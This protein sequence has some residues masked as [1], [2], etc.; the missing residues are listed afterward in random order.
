V[1]LSAEN[2]KTIDGTTWFCSW[3][4]VLSEAAAIFYKVDQLY[5]KQ[6]EEVFV[7]MILAIDWQLDP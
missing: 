5:N 1:V 6:S 3:I 4:S 2:K 7:M